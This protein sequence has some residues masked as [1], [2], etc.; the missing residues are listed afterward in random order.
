MTCASVRRGLETPDPKPEAPMSE[1][2]PTIRP[3]PGILQI[4]LYQGGESHLAGHDRVLKLSS[5]ENP[6]GP[7]PKAIEAFRSAAQSLNIYPNTD[8][9]G[10]RAAIGEVHGLDSDRI[11]CGA[12][13][14]EIIAFLAQAYAGPGREVIHTEHG[15][16][17]YRISALAAGA[18]P[19]EVAE[20][21]RKTD[22]GAILAACTDRT[23][24]VFVA[25]PNNPT[26]T[27]IPASEIASLA[28]GLP[29]AA[30]LVLDGAYA[31]FVPD[32][33][34][35]ADLVDARDNVVMTRTFS[36]IHGLASLRLG[37]MTGPAHVVDAV[38]RIRGPFNV[39]GPAIAAGIVA[40]ADDA[41]VAAAVAHNERWLPWLT[42]EIEALGLKVTP[43]VGNFILIHFP[44][45]AG[46]GARDA[47]AYLTR[48]GLVL[49]AV[50]AYGLPNALRMT[51]GSEEANRLVVKSLAEFLGKPA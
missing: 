8:H 30:L 24:L 3:Q 44:E 13:S 18:D 19:V 35:H 2:H 48:R 1:P 23:S 17:M 29:P 12:G 43:S 22:V 15:F 16:G 14:D 41:H 20:A 39:N 25:N 46:R 32:F 10:L 5:N 42:L 34:G 21:E 33:N 50:G 40:L 47:D 49:R 7:S 6:F 51:V 11:V 31:E 26:G 28:A 9:R 45:N 38:N 37:W 4:A 36:K 27:M